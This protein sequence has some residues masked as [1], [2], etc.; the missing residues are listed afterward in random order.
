MDRLAFGRGYIRSSYLELAC[1]RIRNGEVIHEI[2]VSLRSAFAG[3]RNYP[4][5]FPNRRTVGFVLNR[6][7]TPPGTPT[8]RERIKAARLERTRTGTRAAA[9]T[10]RKPNPPKY[11]AQAAAAPSHSD[12][13]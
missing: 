13:V 7:P 5:N 1:D 9:R 3:R 11:N 8:A 12:A 6:W 10:G 2:A 4:V